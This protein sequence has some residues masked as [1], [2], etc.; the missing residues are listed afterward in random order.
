MT[1]REYRNSLDEQVLNAGALAINEQE[2]LRNLAASKQ[3]FHLVLT[4]LDFLAV[5]SKCALAKLC[6]LPRENWVQITLQTL[7]N[8]FSI[9]LNNE[10]GIFFWYVNKHGFTYVRTSDWLEAAEGFSS[11]ILN[12]GKS[13]TPTKLPEIENRNETWAKIENLYQ[14]TQEQGLRLKFL[15]DNK[16]LLLDTAANLYTKMSALVE[17]PLKLWAGSKCAG[18]PDDEV[19]ISVGDGHSYVVVILKNGKISY[20]V[21]AYWETNETPYNSM[22]AAIAAWVLLLKKEAM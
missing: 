15:L 16:W 13:K 14:A 4:R 17:K 19:A 21:T 5:L 7:D 18:L 2:F 10:N 6:F 22:D 9:S 1:Y 12:A 3:G 11:F 20:A 8:Q